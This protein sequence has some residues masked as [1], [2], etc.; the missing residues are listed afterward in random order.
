MNSNEKFQSLSH[1]VVVEQR[2]ELLEV[3]VEALHVGVDAVALKG[4]KV[5]MQ[6][7]AQQIG[8]AAEGLELIHVQQ[9]HGHQE[10]HAL[11]SIEQLSIRRKDFNNVVIHK[12]LQKIFLLL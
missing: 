1:H 11:T 8:E 9:Q 2:Q 5:A 3:V 4:E 10:A 12:K 7:L 6:L